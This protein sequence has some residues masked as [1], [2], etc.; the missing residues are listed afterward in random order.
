MAINDQIRGAPQEVAQGV[1]QEPAGNET[2]QQGQES[3][4]PTPEEQE[5]YERTVL[6]GIK[7]LTAPE[8]NP[9][10]MEMLAGEGEPAQKLASVTNAIISQLDEQSGGTIPEVVIMPAAGEILENVVEFA[11]E[12]GVMAVDANVQNQATQHLIM[13]LANTYDISPEDL[14]ELSAGMSEDELG[15][16][17]KEQG[18]IAGAGPEVA[19]QVTQQAPQQLPG[20]I[21]QTIGA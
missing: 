18:A 10:I 2:A 14:Q 21:N 16:I 17:V 6:S 4:V 5:A 20:I 9:Q 15:G 13:E 19:P 11:N 7:A 8:S 3:D 1:V 12:S